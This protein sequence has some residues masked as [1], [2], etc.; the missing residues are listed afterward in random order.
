MLLSTSYL[1]CHKRGLGYQVTAVR[2]LISRR[3]RCQY[4]M[5][6]F[7]LK[8]WGCKICRSCLSC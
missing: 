1:C 3:R 7:R 2:P 5:C 8:Y 4:Q 6:D